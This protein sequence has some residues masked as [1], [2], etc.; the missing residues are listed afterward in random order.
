MTTAAVAK[1]H[2][3][4]IRDI[5][6]WLCND[7]LDPH[8]H[9]SLVSLCRHRNVLMHY[10]PSALDFF[11]AERRANRVLKIGAVWMLPAAMDYRVSKT[12]V[13]AGGYL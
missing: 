4:V 11:Q 2:H 8:Q 10:Q 7:P 9:K 1:M 3:S 5:G 12:Y 6:C 13:V